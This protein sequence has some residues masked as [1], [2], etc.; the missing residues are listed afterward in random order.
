[1]VGV[2]YL[3]EGSHVPWLLPLPELALS[4]GNT[5]LEK[6]L[7][8]ICNSISGPYLRPFA[9]NRDWQNATCIIVGENPA[10]ALRDEFATFEDYWRGLTVDPD[11]FNRKY[12]AVRNGRSSKT[13][14][15]VAGLTQLLAPAN[16]LVTNICWYPA[17]TYRKAPLHERKLGK[18]RLTKLIEFCKPKVLFFHGAKSSAFAEMYYGITL[19]RARSPLEQNVQVDG[20]QIFAYHHFSRRGQSQAHVERDMQLFSKMIRQHL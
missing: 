1:M 15:G 9:P 11:V 16:C 17:K 4:K 10:T 19:D 6:Q 18:E 7:K 8:R 5:M 13:S 3:L 2:N 14:Q 20:T 12:A